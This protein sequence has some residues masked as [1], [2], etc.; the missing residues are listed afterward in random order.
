MLLAIIA[1]FTKIAKNIIVNCN[2]N[3]NGKRNCKRYAC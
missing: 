1:N 2:T 3:C